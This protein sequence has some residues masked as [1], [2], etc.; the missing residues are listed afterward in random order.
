[1]PAILLA[2]AIFSPLL[3]TAQQSATPEVSTREVQP[4]FTLQSERNMVTV[5]VVVR[6]GKGEVVENLRREDFQVFDRGKKQTIL[7]FSVEKPAEEA[8]GKSG[9]APTANSGEKLSGQSVPPAAGSA[10]RPPSTVIFPRRFVAL[11]FDDVNTSMSGL[12]HTRDAAN[13]FLKASL[14]PGDRVGVFTSSGQKPLD[15]TDDL[16]KLRQALADLRSH[17]MFDMEKRYEDM[18]PYE[19]YLI[20]EQ[21]DPDAIRLY[22]EP[23]GGGNTLQSTATPTNQSVQPTQSGQ[24]SQTTQTTQTTQLPINDPLR[25]P[26][27]LMKAHWTLEANESRAKVTL[28]RLE[29]LVR[30]MS[31]LPGQRTLVIVSDGFL[32]ETLGDTLSQISERALHANVIINA[33]DARGLYVGLVVADPAVGERQLLRDPN[34]KALKERFMREQALRET[35]GMGTLAHD[36]GGTLFENNNDLEAGLRRLAGTPIVSYTLAFS[37]ADLKHDG[38]FHPLKVSLASGRGLSAQARKGYYAPRK[39]E[40]LAVQEKEDIQEAAFS[41]SE[42]QGIPIQVNAQFFMLNKTDAEID[43][44]THIDIQLVHFRKEGDRNLGNLTLATAVFD[45]DGHYVIGQQKALELR[46]RDQSLGKALE[47]G[48]DIQSELNVK[49]GTY[50]VRTVVRDSASGQVSAVNNT[51]EIPY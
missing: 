37:P 25:V 12:A 19:A 40:D 51:V 13:S 20:A 16:A 39:A 26:Q 14:H 10:E 27:I 34:M 8:A 49:A 50:L 31:S 48:F 41:T 28:A 45:R 11:Y 2:C 35:D 32:T 24:S 43:V 36:T 29:S 38:A 47:T 18:S 3:L 9:P 42:M 33:L 30:I 46:L 15:F 17:P 22:M 6:N 7:Q 21:G 5:R 4:T 23:V 1:M 44:V